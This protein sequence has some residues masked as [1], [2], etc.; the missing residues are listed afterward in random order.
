MRIELDAHAKINWALWVLSRRPDGY[1]Q[2]DMLMQPIALCDRLTFEAGDGIILY[3]NGAPCLEPSNLVLRAAEALVEHTG[4]RRGARIYL[5]KRIPARAGL[6]GGS[7]DCAAALR[8][9]DALWGLGLDE[10]T[11][12]AIGFSL[13]A[14]VPYCLTGGLCRVRG[15]GEIVEKLP[16]GP[17]VFLAMARLGAGLSTGAVFDAWDAAPEYPPQDAQGAAAAL[18]AG[19]FERLR[20]VAKN[21]LIAPAN[22]MM[23]GICRAIEALY[24]CGAHFAMMSGSGST[25]YGVFDQRQAA[26]RAADILGKNSIITETLR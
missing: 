15:I 9:L 23:P 22:A 20:K 4:V 6:G 24:G 12:R 14:D 10:G 16:E 8:G 11:L 25:V 3:L 5:E 1:H 2:L 18:L 7:A 13:G 19:D 17:G 26:Q 21:A